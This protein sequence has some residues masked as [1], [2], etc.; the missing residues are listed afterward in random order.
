MPDPVDDVSHSAHAP[1]ATHQNGDTQSL[2]P[3]HGLTA[4]QRIKHL[5]QFEVT[6]I[7]LLCKTF[8]KYDLTPG[9]PW[10][11]FK[12]SFLVLPDWFRFDLEP[13]SEEYAI[14]QRRLWRLI[15]GVNR[16]Y[17]PHVD[18]QEIRLAHVDAV[19]FP[20]YF[21]RRDPLVVNVAANHILATG[22]IMM[23]S[24]L[25]P[26]QW[27]LEY[28]AGF[29]HT[30]LQ[31]SR[32]G[33]NVDTVDISESHCRHV[34]TQADFFGVPLSSFRGTF[35]WN[36]RGDKKYDFIWFY[37]SFHHCLDFKEVVNQLKRHLAADGRLLLAGEP[38][39]RRESRAVPYP[40]GL[41]I[42]A[43]VVAV[44]RSRHWFELGFTE[45]F[46][47]GLFVAAG[48][49]IRKMECAMSIYGA[50]YICTHRSNRV[51]MGTQWLPLVEGESWHDAQGDGR[52][53]KTHS[54]LT[55]DC[56]ESFGDIEL[57]VINHHPFEQVLDLEYGLTKLR[58]SVGPGERKT[59]AIPAQQKARRL[60][61]RCA[62]F[63]PTPGVGN[64]VADRRSLGI[65]VTELRYR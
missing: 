15:A 11:D 27:A 10:D 52:W 14:Q 13:M 38:I 62:T 35:G 49:T 34:K 4:G 17:D 59:I 24:A 1:L 8:E 64:L 55:L 33:I 32:L 28:G 47:V 3:I 39:P 50:G 36:P 7:D 21:I 19:R 37:E 54:Y 16:D 46:I 9:T 23:H 26:G 12:H 22:M 29:A 48:F 44:M 2:P 56:T 20:G 45:D 40:W 53:T 61:F 25:K 6:D 58:V 51:D 18:E 42:E 30:A 5:G 31:L 57:D 65:Y 63:V 60:D 41:R 43:D